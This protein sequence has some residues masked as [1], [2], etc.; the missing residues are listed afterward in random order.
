MATIRESATYT[1]VIRLNGNGGTV[2]K[3]SVSNSR[4]TNAASTSVTTTIPSGIPTRDGYTFLGYSRAKASNPVDRQPGDTM[5]ASFSRTVTST[6]ME[7]DGNY[8]EYAQNKTVNSYIYAQWRLNAWNV[9]YN[10]GGGSGAPS[11]QQKT[12]GV[13]LTLSVT[14]PTWTGHSFVKWNTQ[15]SGAG[16]DYMPG[17]TYTVDADLVLYAIWSTDEYLVSFDANGGSDAPADQTKLY[18]EPLELSEDIPT[19]TGYDFVSW[20]TAADG[21]GTA[22]MPGDDY[23]GNAALTL[24][25]VWSRTFFLIAYN[26]NGHGTA[27]ASQSKE[28]GESVTIAPAITPHPGCVFVEWNTA[29]DMSCTSYDPAD[30]YSTD[31]D[32]TLYAIWLE[33]VYTITFDADGGTVSPASKQVTAGQPYGELPVPV[34]SGETFYGWFI[35]DLLITENATVELE[36]DTTATAAWS[37]RSQMRTMGTDG[38]LHTGALYVKGSDGNMHMAIAYVK[39]TDGQMH[40]NG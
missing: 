1:H 2:P 11:A 18:G 6:V 27:P 28:Y 32:L 40:V 35:D 10:V 13:N 38:Q 26:A 24:Y 34:K 30:T 37:I 17:D 14:V 19:R 29:A 12:Q 21:T 5:S 39:G 7:D 22:Y 16:T 15:P 20:N 33:G 23:T 31:A 9:T 4:S 36:E 25:A 8:H 3:S